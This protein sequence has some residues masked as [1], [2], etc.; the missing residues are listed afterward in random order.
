MQPSKYVLFSWVARPS[1]A[2]KLGLSSA[3]SPRRRWLISGWRESCCSGAQAA[4]PSGE[5]GAG[6]SRLVVGAPKQP[7]VEK[8]RSEASSVPPTL[9]R[10]S[11]L[12]QPCRAPSLSGASL[13]WGHSSW[14]LGEVQWSGSTKA[15]LS[16]TGRSL[17]RWQ[18]CWFPHR[19]SLR[20]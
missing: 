1:R 15:S 18:R 19:P 5:G 4:A 10:R 14:R 8:G 3:S 6:W 12:V 13:P 16:W 7:V 11:P 9:V 20:E 2:Q 17:V